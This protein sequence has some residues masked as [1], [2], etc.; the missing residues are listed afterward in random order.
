VVARGR[1]WQVT[2]V[3]PS[4][5]PLDPR[6]RDGAEGETMVSLSTVDDEGIGEELSLF[7]EVERE[8]RIL[9]SGTLPDPSG[10]R[11]DE[12]A[13]MGAFLDALRWGAVTNA[14]SL[15]LQAPFRAGIAIEDYQLEPGH[16][17]RG[18]QPASRG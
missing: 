14:E 13:V 16:R 17:R 10:G 11:F 15:V 3:R 8:R 1:H 4:A 7:G 9:E 2:D 5:L 18:R 6:S 12:P